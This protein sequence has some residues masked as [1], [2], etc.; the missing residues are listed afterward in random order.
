MNIKKSLTATVLAIGLA[1]GAGL[2]AAATAEASTLWQTK[3]STSAACWE[4]VNTKVVD[5]MRRGNKI[6]STNCSGLSGGG[7]WGIILYSPK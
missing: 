6:E 4:A 1:A 3:Q 2:S 7:Y 5:L